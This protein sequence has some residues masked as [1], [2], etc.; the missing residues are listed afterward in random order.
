MLGLLVMSSRLPAQTDLATVRGIVADPTGALVPKVA[1][2]LT[3]IATNVSRKAVTNDDGDFE[4]PYVALGTYRLT[5]SAAG[6][7]NFVADN[8]VIRAREIRRIDVKLELGAVGSE[9]T[10]TEKGAAVISTEGSQVANGFS[11]EAFVDSPLSQSFF[12]QAY[13]T[14]LPNIQTAQ[15]GFTIRFAGQSQV[16]ENLD[17]VTSD[18]SV[19]LVQNMNDFEDLQVVAV[20]NSAEFS[21]VAQFSMAGKSGT[22]NFHGKVYYDLINS[23]LNTKRYFDP[24]KIPY[25]EHRGG[26]NI[27]GPIIKNRTFFYF[28]YSLVRI[29]SRSFYNRDVPTEN[30]RRGNFSDFLNQARPVQIKDPFTGE[31]FPRNMIPADRIHPTAAKVQDLYIPKPNQGSPGS[32]FQNY[33]F[34][35]P[36]PTD[37]YRWDSHTDRI[38]H[39]LTERNTV[40][41]RYI[42]RET[43]Y[44][45]NGPFAN[46]GTWTRQR[47]HHSIVANDTHVFSPK[48]VNQFNWGWIKDYFIDGAET[49]GV[50]PPKGDQAVKAIGLQGVNPKGYSEMGF[51]TMTIT[52][53]QQLRQQPGG[54][55]LDQNIFQFTNSVTWSTGKHVVKFGSDTR[56]FRDHNGSIPEGTYGTFAFNGSLTGLGYS[57]FLLGLPYN[58]TRLDPLTDRK[59]KAYEWGMFIT[60]TFK[61][62]RRLSLDY[63]LRWDFFHPSQYEDGLQYNWDPTSGNVVIPEAARGKVSPLYSP[64]IKIVTG[65]V[66]PS[67][68][69]TNSRPRIGVAYRLRDDFVI[70]GGYGQYTEWLGNFFRAQGTGPFQIAESYF[71]EIKN[72]QALLSF[73]N[74]F[75][76]S[77][78]GAAIPS[79]SVSGYPLDTDHGVIHQFNVSI[80]KE[81]GKFGTRLSYIGSRSHGLNYSLGLNK[82]RPSLVP[83]TNARRPYPQ[84][85]NT[86][87][88]YTDGRATYNSMQIEL[89]RKVGAVILDAH[90]TLAS[91]LS[92]TLN[93]EN[94]YDHDFWGRDAYTS[95]HRAVVNATWYLPVG[96][97]KRYLSAAP[98]AV[99]SVLGGW[100]LSWIGYFQ[101]GQYFTPSFSGADPSNTNSFGGLPDRIADGNL[102]PD[103]RDRNRWFDPSAFAIPPAGRFGN[104]GVNILEGPGLNL[105]HISAIKSFRITERAKFVLQSMFTNIAN[106]PHFDFP[107]ANISVPASVARVFQLRQGDGGREM[108]GSRNLQL[109]G[110]IEF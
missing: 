4:I 53:I 34:L 100:E 97:G 72:G 87:F 42:N 44:V 107:N 76:S 66:Y 106:H 94:P 8:I 95:R 25:K 101:S 73:P 99:D 7:R 11:H 90:Y 82:P 43:P 18:G 3:N 64:A 36:F 35:F 6:F 77:L 98:R 40:F 49:G 22:N 109:R 31:P 17:G 5:A 104:S 13:M 48:V 92:N 55:N 15:G 102:P 63:G 32:T 57:D 67:P 108:S 23:A 10:V 20:N 86:A 60:D 2:E 85:V 41:A 19:N 71:N 26:A 74:P 30:M 62:N 9:V 16:S 61:V 37:L 70:R 84:F 52:G 58:S 46:L 75:P 65:G 24:V 12:P 54:V 50:T 21:R 79:Q 96:K 93:L 14:T 59:Q 29:P 68:K 81:I 27:S 83:F 105:H 45:L 1:I 110:R 89:Q 28:G 39:K 78:A 69:K 91:N 88:V 33:G 51:P 56:L 80:E 103:K 38:D 47:K